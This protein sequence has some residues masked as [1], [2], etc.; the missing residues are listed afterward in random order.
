MKNRNRYFS[1]ILSLRL[2]KLNGRGNRAVISLLLLAC[3]MPAKAQKTLFYFEETALESD[4]WSASGSTITLSKEHAREG[5]QALRW[6][7]SSGAKLVLDYSKKYPGYTLSYSKMVYIPVY[8]LN[9]GNDKLLIAFYNGS[10]KICEGRHDLNYQGWLPFQRYIYQDFGKY[11]TQNFNRI[12][13]TY[14][15]SEA[16]NS[17]TLW[18]D[19]ICTSASSSATTSNNN[20]YTCHL[21]PQM[22]TDYRAGYFPDRSNLNNYFMEAYSRTMGA[23]DSIPVSD[24]QLAEVDA[25]L[26]NYRNI[27]VKTY[28]GKLAEATAFVND[29]N[30]TETA[31][32][33]INASASW[34]VY[35]PDQAY[36]CAYYVASL[37]YAA[38]DKANGTAKDNLV[39]LTRY[40]LD[41]GVSPGGG[42]VGML[43]SNYTP[44]REFAKG[45]LYAMPV[46]EEYDRTHP[47]ANL[48]KRVLQLLSW[49]YN[50]GYIYNEHRPE[51][52]TLDQ[53]HVK[54]QFYY[55]LA[56]FFPTARERASEL[57]HIV[58]FLERM[59]E[60]RSGTV[61]VIKPD[62]LGFHHGAMHNSY[63][64]GF[65]SWINQV[66]VLKGSSF[67]V[68]IDAYENVR[69]FV[70][71]HYLQCVT[72]G[73]SAFYSN[74]QCGRG[75]FNQTAG[76]TQKGLEALASIGGDVMGV[77][78]DPQVAA[79]C[80]FFYPGSAFTDQPADLNGFYQM[81]YGNMGVFR[82]KEYT[83][84]MRG[85]S[86]DFWGTEIYSNANRFGRYQSYGTTEVLY[87]RSGGFSSSGYPTNYGWDW[88]VV[89]GTTTVHTSWKEL[90]PG[91]QESVSRLPRADEYQSNNFAGSLS[92]GDCGLFALDFKEDPV[93]TWGGPAYRYTPTGLT[94]KKTVFACD[95]L[96]ICLGSNIKFNS[97][98]GKVVTTNLFQNIISTNVGALYLNGEGAVSND[99]DTDYPLAG[100]PFWLLTPAGTGYYIPASS[101]TLHVVKGTQSTPDPYIDYTT[102]PENFPMIS[103]PVAKA[104]LTHSSLTEGDRYQ[105]VVAPN[106]TAAGMKQL[107]D[108]LNRHLP[109]TVLKQDNGAHILRMENSLVTAYSFFAAQTDLTSLGTPVKKVDHPCLLITRENAELNKLTLD[110]ALPDVMNEQVITVTLK[111]KWSLDVVPESVLNI[112][113]SQ[114]DVTTFSVRLKDGLKTR[115]LFSSLLSSLKPV[116]DT[117][118]KL[119]VVVDKGNC[120]VLVIIP[121]ADKNTPVELYNSSGV[122]ISLEGKLSQTDNGVMINAARLEP[123]LYL[124]RTIGRNGEILG[125]KLM[126]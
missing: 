55:N 53:V 26:A 16:G 10:T 48:K 123:G 120:S 79:L 38:I 8:C 28:E 64:Y 52:V 25:L 76:V 66:A 80:K 17:Q 107:A 1:A 62:G 72:T 7:A 104:W 13:I 15:P 112:D 29:R 106:Q 126:W 105:F 24:M 75:P 31:D 110:I 113:N 50:Y 68:G 121:G 39:K 23:K 42:P 65:Q 22:T 63:M 115:L 36:N 6:Q 74:A 51:L 21:G 92:G 85:L 30:I 34:L 43:S 125:S 57:R 19:G 97:G 93:N 61:G 95:S 71:T 41:Y 89:P 122:R 87:N 4:Y 35:T 59:T 56:S 82:A 70:T 117:N 91:G 67:R 84:T 94:F 11:V 114:S 96:L 9:P 118:S 77:S 47:G 46:Y 54:S 40:L 12:E 44:C 111:G 83:V 101:A 116:I 73:T 108:Q 45:F 33:G 103:N 124:I 18:L 37:A 86:A 60:L 102:L 3:L 88:N 109:Y 69:K 14:L 99:Q 78:Y 119:S 32:G 49:C 20:F 58:R 2:M 5:A 81:N 90:N 100:N 27:S 98:L